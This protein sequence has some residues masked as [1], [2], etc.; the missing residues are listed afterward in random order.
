MSFTDLKGCFDACIGVHNNADT[1]KEPTI[2][3]LKL[4]VSTVQFCL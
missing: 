3:Y 2:W 4:V 1:E